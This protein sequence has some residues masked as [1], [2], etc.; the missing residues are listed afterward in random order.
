[1]DLG[2]PTSREGI[3]SPFADK[4]EQESLRK[5]LEEAQR[6]LREAEHTITGLRAAQDVIRDH[7]TDLKKES[8]RLREELAVLRSQNPQTGNTGNE[9]NAG[10]TVTLRPEDVKNLQECVR[11]IK[12]E[13]KEIRQQTIELRDCMLSNQE[14]FSR[15]R[16]HTASDTGRNEEESPVMQ[17]L[18]S[19][20]LNFGHLSF[21]SWGDLGKST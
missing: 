16:R 3:Q 12:H 4:N 7:S 2:T 14:G 17:F 19:C 18:N 5:Q 11:E 15:K 13:S 10:L 9:A 1:M 8:N 21:M 6:R 20:K